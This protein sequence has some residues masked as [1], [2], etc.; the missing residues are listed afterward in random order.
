MK[1]QILIS[2]KNIINISSAEFAD[3]ILMIFYIYLI[4][5]HSVHFSINHLKQEQNETDN[6]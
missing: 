3:D 4:P 6:Y 1:C 2:G 5:K